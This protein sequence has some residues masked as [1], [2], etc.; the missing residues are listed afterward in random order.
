[1]SVDNERRYTLDEAAAILRS[2]K[3]TVQIHP[4]ISKDLYDWIRSVCPASV[5]G[6][7]TGLYAL[8]NEL[9][10]Y[11]RIEYER[12]HKKRTSGRT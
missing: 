9:L 12:R 1:M 3:S 10:S 4:M 6:K 5:K 2:S 7:R 8:V 11:G